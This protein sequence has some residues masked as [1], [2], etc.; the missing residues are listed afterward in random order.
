M[1]YNHSYVGFICMRNS[2]TV[3]KQFQVTFKSDNINVFVIIS[4][5]MRKHMQA[6]NFEKTVSHGGPRF[7]SY[8]NE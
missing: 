8:K 2:N 1:G 7:Q 6:K 3:W 5:R 4:I